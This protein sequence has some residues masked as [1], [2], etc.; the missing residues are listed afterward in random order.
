MGHQEFHVSNP[1][2]FLE[3]GAKKRV[4]S[5]PDVFSIEM[6]LKPLAF[7]APGRS[8]HR[9]GVDPLSVS[10]WLRSRLLDAYKTPLASHPLCGRLGAGREGG[11]ERVLPP[12][13][14]SCRSSP[15]KA[16]I[17]SKDSY[18]LFLLALVT[19]LRIS[20]STSK[21]ITVLVAWCVRP[22][23]VIAVATVSNGM[24]IRPWSS[25]SSALPFLIC[26]PFFDSSVVRHFFSISLA[27]FSNS[28]ASLTDRV[29]A[30]ANLATQ[31]LMPSCALLE[32]SAAS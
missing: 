28:K 14:A 18:A 4:I 30:A 26:V 25:R 11:D 22:V 29:Q 21:P 3:R 31:R 7:L 10:A 5:S 32:F 9:G 12:G 19:G 15:M 2:H 23:I 20:A 13:L 6:D 24:P 8:D 1:T 17:I 27:V 16:L